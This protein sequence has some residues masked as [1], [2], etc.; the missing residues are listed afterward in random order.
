M[1]RHPCNNLPGATELCNYLDDDCD[2]IADDNLT[3]L[4]SYQD[5][6]NDNFGNQFIDSLSCELPAGYVSDSTD[7]DDTNPNIYPGA[8]EILNGLDDDCDQTADEGLP[9]NELQVE[10]ISLYPNPAFNTIQINSNFSEVGIF[11]VYTSTGQK[12]MSGIWDRGA[13][14]ISI[15]KLAQ[16]MYLIQLDAEDVNYKC[17]FIKL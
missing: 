5:A 1:Q 15:L 11:T 10:Q 13:Q 3:Y 2:G 14:V 6:D 16:G 8:V 4:H 12:V 17:T 9:I 7:C